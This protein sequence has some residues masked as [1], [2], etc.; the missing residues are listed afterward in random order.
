MLV[1]A[2]GFLLR[3]GSAAAKF[4]FVLYLASK[5]SSELLGQVA[6]LISVSSIFT[7]IAGLEINQVVGRQLHSLSL[8]NKEKLFH[9]HALA[10]FSLY[11]VLVPMLMMLYSDQLSTNWLA[12]VCIL[13]FEHLITEVYRYSI[14]MLRHTYASALLF[15]KNA[16]WTSLF[17]L[18]TESGMADASFG[19]IVQ[20]WGGTLLLTGIPLIVSRHFLPTIRVFVKPLEWIPQVV[21]LVCQ[22]RTFIVSSIALAFIGSFDK[23]LIDQLYTPAELGVY[24]FFST[25]TSAIS[26]LVSFSVGSISGPRCIKIF[27][28]E[29]RSSYLRHYRRLVQLYWLTTIGAVLLITVPAGPLLVFFGKTAFLQHIEILYLL[30]LAAALIV[31][32]EPY[33]MTAY[34][35]G[36][37]L[38]LVVGNVFHLISQVICMT[39][40]S[41]LNNFTWVAV[42]ALLSAVLVHVYF[43]TGVAKRLID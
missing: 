31:L 1:N 27:A 26:L 35:E 15:I 4:L 39:L 25:C 11:M 24:F 8:K 6:I 13:V 18:L 34:L 28:T 14:L 17:V 37:D 3:G 19:L 32:C 21:S 16:G 9:Y 20:C 12:V 41:L 36:R 43:A 10:A 30:T 29:D 2:I 5:T 33:K 7:Q 22:A 23:L 38:E 40:F 42:G